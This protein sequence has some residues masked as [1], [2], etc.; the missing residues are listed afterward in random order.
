MICGRIPAN[1]FAFRLNVQ[2]ELPNVQ[3]QMLKFQ[4]FECLKQTNLPESRVEVSRLRAAHALVAPFGLAAPFGSRSN[5]FFLPPTHDTTMAHNQVNEIDELLK[6]LKKTPG[7][8][9]YLILNSDGVVVRWDQAGGT[10]M[11]YQRAV[12]HAHHVTELYMK[13]VAHVKE[14]FDPEDGPVENVRMRTG[15]YEMIVSSLGA[16]TLAVF[17]EDGAKAGEGGVE[18]SAVVA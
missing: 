3:I 14:L 7:F 6:D 8:Q 9:A 4:Q 10:Q 16:Y 2:F 12:Q 18:A 17:Q 13:S 11:P 5:P 15:E 1:S